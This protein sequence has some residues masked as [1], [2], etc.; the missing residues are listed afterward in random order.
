LALSGRTMARPELGPSAWRP[1]WGC[2]GGLSGEAFAILSMVFLGVMVCFLNWRQLKLHQTLGLTTS[3]ALLIVGF[4]GVLCGQGHTF[5]PVAVAVSTAALLAWKEPISGFAVGL[6]DLELRSAILLAI[7]SFIIYPVLPTHAIDPWGLIEP[8]TTWA[9]VILIAALGFVNYVLWKIYGPRS[10]VPMVLMILASI[11]FAWRSL[12][13]RLPDSEAPKLNLEQPFSLS[14][15][16]RFG[17][18][19]LALHVAGTLAQRYLGMFGFYAVS[20]AG[21]ML[22]SASAVAAA[23]A[24]AAHNEVPVRIAANGALLASLTSTLI[25][26]LLVARVASQ[27]SLTTRLSFALCVI[28]AVGIAGRQAQGLIGLHAPISYSYF[29][30]L[31]PQVF[32][33]RLP[34]DAQQKLVILKF[35]RFGLAPHCQP[36]VRRP[37]RPE[38]EMQAHSIALELAAQYLARLRLVLRQQVVPGV[39]KV[40]LAAEPAKCLG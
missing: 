7:L 15:A 39:D 22:S 11:L 31:Q 24:A 25:D 23:G 35:P 33:V 3:A 17:L 8:Q 21:G 27:R 30:G 37:D 18:I 10:V 34:P 28:G 2:L 26:I 16:L 19:F 29:R 14:A 32:Y 13:Q 12:N 4:A 38:I 6:S 1:C 5:T 9:T 20:I 40:H 36:A